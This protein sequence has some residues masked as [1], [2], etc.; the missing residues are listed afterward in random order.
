MHVAPIGLRNSGC[1]YFITIM[2]RKVTGLENQAPAQ[3]SLESLPRGEGWAGG[4]R[5]A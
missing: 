4:V 1:H 5:E 3:E 2:V